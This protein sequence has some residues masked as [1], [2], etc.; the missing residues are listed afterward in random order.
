MSKS[1]LVKGKIPA[2]TDCPYN[3]S[4]KVAK[5]G[6]C[7]HYGKD[8]P[9]QYSCAVARILTVIDGLLVEENRITA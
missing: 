6:Q 1:K 8:H 7:G 2:F 5:A 9:V 4:C 3:R